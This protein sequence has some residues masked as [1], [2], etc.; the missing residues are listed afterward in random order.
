ML[1][2]LILLSSSS[3]M[4][5]VPLRRTSNSPINGA[6]RFL[7]NGVAVK[8]RDNVIDIQFLYTASVSVGTPA[9][10]FNL[11]LDTGSSVFVT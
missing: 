3:G 7:N 2:I 1:F 9:Q 5:N 8:N 4:I 6:R 11:Q 10:T